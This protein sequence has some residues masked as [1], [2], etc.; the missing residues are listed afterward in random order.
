MNFFLRLMEIVMEFVRHPI[1]IYGYTFSPWGIS[2][3]FAFAGI[4]IW[5]IHEVFV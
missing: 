1:T 2:L 3:F 4:T 5:F